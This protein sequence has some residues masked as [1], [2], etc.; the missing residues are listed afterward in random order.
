MHRNPLLHNRNRWGRYSPAVS[1]CRQQTTHGG[2]LAG[3]PGKPLASLEAELGEE[4]GIDRHLE[5]LIDADRAAVAL[6][7]GCP[8]L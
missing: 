6:I 3:P 4:I 1:D 8:P 5:Q 2:A 7:T